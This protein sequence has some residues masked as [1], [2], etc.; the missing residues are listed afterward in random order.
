MYWDS[1]HVGQTASG[2]EI[3]QTKS[4]TGNQQEPT[5]ADTVL[6]LRYHPTASILF[7]AAVVLKP[8]RSIS[9]CV[10]LLCLRADTRSIPR[11]MTT[12]SGLW[13]PAAPGVLKAVP[14]PIRWSL[15]SYLWREEYG[16]HVYV[17]QA[18]TEKS[19]W[20]NG[21]LRGRSFNQLGGSTNSPACTIHRPTL[22]ELL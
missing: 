7:L 22:C 6:V 8:S 18:K 12:T 3:S 17:Q 5:F 19:A 14:P 16:A 4:A 20:K 9:S 11:C 21:K 2:G 15:I 13:N 10:Y 1:N